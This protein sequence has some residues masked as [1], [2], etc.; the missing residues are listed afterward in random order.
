[1]GT[2][3][4]KNAGRSKPDK[5]APGWVWMLGG[6]TIGLL[7]ALLIYL[8]QQ[9]SVYDPVET[10]SSNK[11]KTRAVKKKTTNTEKK[12]MR[13]EF[14]TLLPESEVV[15][16]EQ[17]LT[18]RS[19][20]ESAHRINA[21]EYVLQ[22]GSF[23]HREDAEGLRAKLA[24]L[25]IEATIQ[26]VTVNNDTWHRVRAGSFKSLRDINETRNR[27][28]ENSINAILVKVKG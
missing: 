24:L 3:D 25:G 5:A 26:T 22:A 9:P 21:S 18:E 20:K 7:V 10:A 19:K 15:I 4:Y 16:P 14:Y 2:R 6:L 23:R 27:L 12:G 11:S 17:E 8:N 1:M 28:R 13:Y